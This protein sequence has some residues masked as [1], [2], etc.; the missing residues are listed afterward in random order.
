[1]IHPLT[2]LQFASLPVSAIISEVDGIATPDLS[3][4]LRVV[5][6]KKHDES[7]RIRYTTLF[8]KVS[9]PPRRSRDYLPYHAA[10]LC[11]IEA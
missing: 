5:A 10:I 7:L 4:F 11:N 9:P 8:G 3:T 6:G 1:M 2:E